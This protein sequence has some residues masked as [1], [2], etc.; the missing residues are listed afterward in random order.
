MQPFRNFETDVVFKDYSEDI[1]AHMVKRSKDLQ[2][3][4]PLAKH[5][6]TPNLRAKMVDWMIEVLCSYKCKDQCFFL[7]TSYMDRYFANKKKVLLPG[8]L[9]KL[10]IGCM[11][12]AAKYEEIY[13]FKLSLVYKKIAHKKIS[14][15]DIRNQ[16]RDILRTLNFDISVVTLYDQLM[17]VVYKLKLNELMSEKHFRYLLKVC[18]YLSKMNMYDYELL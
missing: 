17:F 2:L 13:P 4:S 7:A 9:H 1:F 6:I 8:D 12:V 10:G 15:Q 18:V 16:E 5:S 11:F 14:R 3:H